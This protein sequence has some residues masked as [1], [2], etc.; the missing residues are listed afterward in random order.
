MFCPFCERQIKD[1]SLF[2]KYCG[3]AL[4]Q[5]SLPFPLTQQ[6]PQINA[7]PQTSPRKRL[8]NNAKKGI[9]TGILIVGLIIVVLLIYYPSI[10]PWNW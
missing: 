1:N 9:V 3:K 6:I 5:K 7:Q 10:F 4:P 8:S 2:C